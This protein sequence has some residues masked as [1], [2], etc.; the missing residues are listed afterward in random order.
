[1]IYETSRKGITVF[2]TTHYMDEAEYC[3]RVAIMVD[4]RIE[5]MDSPAGL[6]QTY[7]QKTMDD[8]FYVLARKAI[9]K[10]D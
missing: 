3:N 4:G 7:N 5:A 8:V 9:R 2:A 1:M 10:A 6:K